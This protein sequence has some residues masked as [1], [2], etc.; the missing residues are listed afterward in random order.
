MSA[1]KYITKTET[2]KLVRAALKQHFPGVTF[3]VTCSRGSVINV[4]WEDGPTTKMV[5]RVTSKFGG[6]SFDG[7]I[8]LKSYH[9]SELNG[10][11]VHF[12]ADWVSCS[13]KLS[14]PALEQA[15]AEAKRRYG[16]DTYVTEYG[17]WELVKWDY[18]DTHWVNEL[19]NNAYCDAT[20]RVAAY[21]EV[22]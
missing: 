20:G 22:K 9:D 8:D 6:A 11:R 1:T 5:Q 15:L 4:R 18:S 3:G 16:I 10:E 14:R 7:M 19:V 13:R 21:V 17:G 2:A 12:C